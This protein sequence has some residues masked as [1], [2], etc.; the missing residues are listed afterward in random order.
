MKHEL[1]NMSEKCKSCGR[2][3]QDICLDDSAISSICLADLF[4]DIDDL[5]GLI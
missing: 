4:F 2:S 5:G 1:H 3:A